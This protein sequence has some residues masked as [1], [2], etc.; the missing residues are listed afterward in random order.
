MNGL[1]AHV[2]GAGRRGMRLVGSTCLLLSLILGWVAP[3]QAAPPQ[4]ALDPSP[5]SQT[6]KLIFI[7]HSTGENW[8]RD[9]YG[10]LGQALAHNNYFVSDTN[11][12]WGPEAIGDRT[13]IPNWL[14]WFRSDNTP[15][16]MQALFNESG[17][18]SE[19]SR[20]SSDPGGENQVILFK[21]CFPNSSLEG[22]PDDPP[23]PGEDLTVGNAKFVYN[24]IL[25]FFAT[26]PDKLF[27][28]ITAPPLSDREYAANA[29]AFN[30][31]L[32]NDWLRENNYTLPNVAVFDFYNVLTGRDHHHR[33]QA[34]QIEHVFNPGANTLVYPS[35][36]DHPSAQGSRK[37]SEEFIP[38]LNA[39]Y[40]RWQAAG[41]SA[42]GAI[43]PPAVV[44]PGETTR[45][46]PQ[47][48][49]L[50]IDDFEGGAPEGSWGWEAFWDESTPTSID[51]A[52]VQDNAYNGDLA[53]QIEYNVAANAWA[54]C[55]LN[56]EPPQ[57]WSGQRGIWFALRA[58]QAGQVFNID[59]YT[60]DGENK[61]T[62]LYT[63]ETPPESAGAWI[64]LELR[65][66]DFHRA[67]WEENGGQTFNLPGEISG[68]GFGFPTPQDAPNA[69]T[70]WIDKLTA[71]GADQPVI[72][73]PP[74][75][76]PPEA[77]PTLTPPFSEP[78][79]TP[80]ET[81]KDEGNGCW[82]GLALPLG[83]VGL[84]GQQLVNRR[85]RQRSHP[86][87]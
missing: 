5:P 54:T 51:C 80:E 53:L 55:T 21:S 19:Y 36:D 79:A 8:L 27:I 10:G 86:A 82:L 60:R 35:D 16:Y 48:G 31:W 61:A 81:E 46:Q 40:H 4:Q 3:G 47:G 59:L 42:P 70:I 20:T 23:T 62:W 50:L 75:E 76:A 17:Q 22:S 13:D 14:E 52:P 72:A 85:R 28:V 18:N 66:E 73:E 77:A 37:A 32:V 43:A 39:F 83:L 30:L 68:I 84:G 71:L 67:D 63:I 57:N 26:R 24:E 49:D 58:V 34:G 44:S 78:S 38:L 41:E 56:F 87:W 69:G 12:G 65:W 45:E 6:V 29:R 11:Y 2:G 1:A 7:H 25:Q 64:S 33:L 9:D 15:R 74:T